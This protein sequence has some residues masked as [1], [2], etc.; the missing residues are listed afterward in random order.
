MKRDY[1]LIPRRQP[2][3]RDR[4]K[5]KHCKKVEE[6]HA[7][8]YCQPCYR[9]VGW[10]PKNVP[11]T[12]CEKLGPHKAHGLCSSCYTRLHQF[13]NMAKHNAKRY[14][15]VNY[16]I[17]EELI[18]QCASCSFS[19]IVQIHHLDYNI[20]NSARNN[21]VGLCPNCHKMIH[22][23]EHFEEI[24]KNLGTKGI[25]VTKITKKNFAKS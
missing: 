18:Q 4:V 8:G 15:G 2:N 1:T 10:T 25:D 24:K 16:G 7:K 14:H 9:K 13:N 19:K 12:N 5:C 6:H 17:F 20:K 3:E 22:R 21:L 23:F 11:C